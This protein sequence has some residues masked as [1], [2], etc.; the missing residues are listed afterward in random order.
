MTSVG[1]VVP[2]YNYSR[3]LA[4]R[5][6]SILAQGD[7]ISKLV[8][9]DDASTDDSMAVATP[10]LTKFP[11][12]VVIERNTENSNSVF[13]QWARGL[14]S[15]DTPFVWIAEADDGAE[16][17]M[18][19]G[20]TRRLMEDEGSI[21]AFSDSAGIGP[22]DEILEEN[23]KCYAAAMGDHVL[24]SD[25]TLS[26][27]EFMRRCLC[28]R[29]LVV[30][31]S[32]VLWRTEALRSAL[33]RLGNEISRWRCAGDWRIYAEAVSAG[34]RVH[35]DARPLNKHRRHPGSVTNKIPRPRL[36]AEV[37][38]MHAVLRQFLGREA[39]QDERMRLHLEDLRRSWGLQ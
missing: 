12:E 22:E 25:A 7:M 34:G 37:V 29:N 32:A 36:F 33:G 17:G 39:V 38:S 5:L 13:L 23:S 18:L 30:S 1:V 21:F 9:L 20:L 27:H 2:N 4:A 28:P 3:Y 26:A 8:F 11:C 19:N 6:S 16:P 35:Y 14:E 31:A 10:L 15:I 24:G